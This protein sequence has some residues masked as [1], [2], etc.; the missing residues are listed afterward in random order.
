VKKYLPWILTALG[1][2]WLLLGLRPSRSEGFHLVEFGRLPVLLN[3]RIQPLDSIARNALMQLRTKQS[4]IGEN[5]ASLSAIEWLAEVLMRPRK[6]D[7][8][9]VFRIDHPELATLLKLPE[10]EKY[11]SFNQITPGIDELEKQAERINQIESP[12]RNPFEKQVI[13][14]Y[15]TVSLY[16]RLKN[17]LEPE[18]SPDFGRELAQYQK[19]I[20]A[21]VA[22]VRARE[23]GKDFD[24][25]TFNQFL[26]WLSRYEVMANVAYPLMVPLDQ[27]GSARQEF[28][29]MGKVLMDLPRGGALPAAVTFYANMT[30]AFQQDKPPEFN[31][32]L[33]AYNQW[34]QAGYASALQTVDRE[35][36]Y[37]F[38]QPFYKAMVIYLA[39]ALLGCFSW[40]NGSDAL[41]RSGYFLMVLALI[42]HS[43]GLV[44]RMVIEGRPPVTNLYS[45]AVFIGWGAVVLGLGLERIFRDGLG[46][47]ASG[48]IG[49][50]TL[51]VAHHLALGGD[52]MEPLRAV[53]D[54]NF[55]LATHVVTVTL[56]YSATF[57]AGFLAVFYILRGFL[58]RSLTRSA[59]AGLERMVY[60]ILCFAT[61]FSFVGTVLGGIWADQSWGRFWGWDPKENGA[62]IIVLWNAAFLHARWGRLTSERGLMN[63]AVF[64]NAVTS[65]S[66]FG[67]NMLGIGLHSYGFMDEAFKWLVFFVVLQMLVIVIGC[68]PILWWK[69]Y[70]GLA[71]DPALTGTGDLAARAV[72]RS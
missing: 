53:L 38:L 11:F 29:S 16:H 40:F 58:T 26:K 20:P 2:A 68:L 31:Q 14:L 25:E 34:L 6:A 57:L 19:F 39:A 59:A 5:G 33:A 12:L 46:I 67:V 45:S 42:V 71:S 21:G 64:G 49:F 18:D 3:G 15:N 66:W 30:M 47:V 10:N 23:N 51:I 55:W 36:L 27:T 32:A 24:Q 52:T 43:L 56:G 62:L 7:E 60:G 70:H 61:F 65:F 22:A 4:L 17:S 35:A 48:S 50:T 13:R 41:R 9:K 63:M 28:T 1:A 44:L 72:A 37:N 54:T 8:R 69:S